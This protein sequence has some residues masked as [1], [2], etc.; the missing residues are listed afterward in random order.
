MEAVISDW[1]VEAPTGMSLVPFASGTPDSEE[2]RPRSIQVVPIKFV[3]MLIH[4]DNASAAMAFQELA[5]VYAADDTL[6]AC[7]DVL[8]W[9]RV[10]LLHCPR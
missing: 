5:G 3:A 1:L 2:I 7:G 4:R 10:A 9:L 8:A 6:E